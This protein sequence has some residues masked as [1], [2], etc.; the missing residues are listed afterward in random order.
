[1]SA[2]K[3]IKT[4][5]SLYFVNP[6]YNFVDEIKT[7]TDEFFITEEIEGTQHRQR[8]VVVDA[9]DSGIAIAEID[10]D[11]FKKEKD[12][13]NSLLNLL[14]MKKESLESELNETNSAIKDAR[15]QL[16]GE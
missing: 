12:A 9:K 16:G 15:G 8:V 2:S 10:I 13:V 7:L 3:K 5:T 6:F 14:D 1:M 11:A 4:G